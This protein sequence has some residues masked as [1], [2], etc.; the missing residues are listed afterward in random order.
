MKDMTFRTWYTLS[1]EAVAQEFETSLEQGLSSQAAAQRLAEVGY[2][3]LK[4]RP[5]PGFWTKLLAQ[6]NDFVILLLIGAS[7]I[8]LL[9][10]DY[11]EATVIMAI[12]V[13]NAAL[14]VMQESKAEQALS[15]LQKMA[16]PEACVIRDGRR[17]TIPAREVAPGDIVLLETGNYVPADVR[18]IESV[19]L[20]IEEAALT[21]ESLPVSKEA[22]AILEDK[23]CL[24]DRRNSAFMNTLV[25]Y[26]RGRGLVT[27][28]GMQTEIGLIA[29]LLQS[30]E[31]E[32][33]P[34][35]LKLDR[36]G[37]TLGLAALVICA[38]V[39]VLGVLRNPAG[40]PLGETVLD[41]F[42][43]A[44]S[45]AIAAVPE[46]LPAIVTIVLALGMQR[47]IKRHALL[48]K[49]PAVETLGSA[50]VICSDKTGTLTQNEMTA[51]C[52]WVEGRFIN[53]S[54]EGYAP[55]GEFLLNG[56]PYYPAGRQPDASLLR[57]GALCNDASLVQKMNGAAVS[58]RITGD[59][60]EGA[61]VVAAA[62][63][64]LHQE[65]LAQSLP[66]VAEI[67]FDS[68]RKRM[69]TIHQVLNGDFDSPYVALVKGAPD[70]LLR[71]CRAIWQDGEVRRLSL[72][73][74]ARVLE[75]NEAMASRALRVLAA[76]YRPLE[77]VPA[78]PAAPEVEHDLIFLGL[79]GMID[80]ARPEVKPAIAESRA[81][82]IKT[83]MIT[84]DYP[85]TAL[86]IAEQLEMLQRGDR[87][88]VGAQL[89]EMSDSELLEQVDAVNIY[90]RVS[91]QHKLK[92]VEA[93]QGR[94]HIVAMTGDG[95]NDAPALK[96][97]NIGV[98]M[99][100]TGADASKEVADMVLTDDN[101][102]SIVAAIE[103]G[104]IIYAN[105]R[106]FVF[107]LLSCNV[108]EI[109]IIFLP[110]LAGLPLPLTAVQLLVL[111]LITDGAPALALGMEKGDPDVMSRPP[112]PAAEPVINHDMLVGILIQSVVITGAVLTAFLVGLNR[113][114]HGAAGL[115]VARTI[116]FGTLSIGEL[117]R[118]YTSRS[119]RYGILQIGPFSNKWM[120][121]AVL[122]SLAVLLVIIYVPFLDPVFNTASLG[123]REWG[124]MLPLILAPAV[125][126]ELT[127]FFLRTP[128]WRRRF[129][130]L[131]PVGT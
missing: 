86:A 127:K 69:T 92:I 34:L 80:M 68:E 8:S 41:M 20:R 53:I 98:A 107:Y 130:L 109:L 106:K 46:G 1:A 59:P 91:P 14:G 89:D 62:K 45:L 110:M 2:N 54:G 90:A 35:Q 108:A 64:G 131:K 116:A 101:Y 58:W 52:L 55:T 100:I 74:R 57:V 63:A 114:G 65:K 104:R 84:G 117:L 82:G 128:G 44:V 81:A 24:G 71:E 25:I 124:L 99:G 111:N 29:E 94:G 50:T 121:Y 95:I 66:R 9:L 103:E 112:R 23:A 60:T 16:A 10:G 19:N 3:E 6:F 73:E 118:A 97:A 122:S 76:A 49:L 87:L 17:Q 123:W 30:D 37:R 4:E 75:A 78:N 79:I 5:R 33:T 113:Y 70:I 21:G 56:Q 85:N 51:V 48:R 125:A 39:F 72:E 32:A 12:V 83:V 61:L 31:I 126:A 15:T 77:R 40:T 28:T 26:G 11:L 88:L 102:T 22:G 18:L 7:L 105:I 120:Q 27:E 38:L 43:V 42:I 36:L 47:M 67:P 93:L 119:E 129:H 13:L 115:A 96:R